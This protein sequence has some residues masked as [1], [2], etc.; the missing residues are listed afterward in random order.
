[1]FTFDTGIEP[2]IH[3]GNFLALQG[4]VD[5][6]RD[7][8]EYRT[9]GGK[10]DKYSTYTLSFPLMMKG[11]FN[12]GKHTLGFY[13]GAYISIPVPTSVPEITEM[14]LYGILGGLDFAAKAGPGAL[15]FDLRFSWD[16]GNTDIPDTD[17]AYHRMF[18]TLSAG[19]KFGFIKRK[20]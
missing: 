10:D 8:A 13:G 4:G 1:V 19:Y 15:L 9:A 5:F 18:I 14:P 12:P 7:S 20:H 3:F 2:E 17:Y 6:A 11:I 16:M